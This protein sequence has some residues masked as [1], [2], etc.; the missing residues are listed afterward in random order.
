MQPQTNKKEIPKTTPT[1]PTPSVSTKP[2]VKIFREHLVGPLWEPFSTR[3]KD[4]DAAF[5]ELNQ[6]MSNECG[7]SQ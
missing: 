4:W 5:K 7:D 1:E 2:F 3:P 6:M